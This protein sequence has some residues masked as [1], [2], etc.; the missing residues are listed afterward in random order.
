VLASD[1]TRIVAVGVSTYQEPNLTLE[2]GAANARALAEA[3]VLESGCAI[4]PGNVTLLCDRSASRD[5]ILQALS[6]AASSCSLDGTLIFYFSGHGEQSNGQFYLL[7]TEASSDNLADTAISSNDLN[8]VLTPC[9]ARGILIILDCCKSAGFAENAQS[10]FTT[11]AGYDFRLLLSASR[12]GQ[13]SFEFREAQGTLF[14]RAVV[15]VVR[16]DAGSIGPMA[17]VVYFSDLFDYV[18]KQ[19]AE[20]LES[21]GNSPEMQEPVFAGTYNRDPRL[22]ILKRLSLERLEAE[23]PRY[24]GKFVRRRIRRLATMGAGFLI[25]FLAGY[26][27]YLDHSLYVWHESSIVKGREGDFLSIYSGDPRFNWSWLGFPHRIFTTDIGV[28]ALDSAVRPG[29]GTPLLTHWSNYIKGLLFS[30]LSPE[31]QTTVSVWN[32][33]AVNAWKYAKSID[34]FDNPGSSGSG[35]AAVA[36]GWISGPK[37]IDTLQNLAS[38]TDADVSTLPVLR[39]VAALAP[40]Q[41]LDILECGFDK[42]LFKQAVMEGLAQPC[43]PTVA[44]FLEREVPTPLTEGEIHNAWYGAGIRTGCGLS[45]DILL[46]T[47][48]SGRTLNSGQLDWLPLLATSPPPGFGRRLGLVLKSKIEE[49]AHTNFPS[50]RYNDLVVR[51]WIELRTLAALWPNEVPQFATSL[52]T[53]PYVYVRYSA[54]YALA[55]KSPEDVGPIAL[56]HSADPWVLTGLV[57]GGWFDE[58]IIG[59]SIEAKATQNKSGLNA[60]AGAAA[61]LLLRTLRLRHLV[62]AEGLAR[63]MAASNVPMIKLEALR[64]LDSLARPAGASER[65]RALDGSLDPSILVR[66]DANDRSLLLD[67]TYEWWVR[68]DSGA[69]S[70][71]LKDLGDS[72]DEAA[73]VLGKVMIPP[74]ILELLRKALRDPTTALKAATLLAMRGS[75]NDLSKLLDSPD[76]NLRNQGLLYAVYNPDVE[77]YL[78]MCGSGDRL[79][80]VCGYLRQQEA[81]RDELERI[82]NK[83]PK[84]VRGLAFSVLGGVLEFT[85]W[86]ADDVPDVS[87][88]IRLWLTD[89]IDELEGTTVDQLER[90]IYTPPPIAK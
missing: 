4:P 49:L 18:Q 46:K 57:R 58:A 25:L 86:A 55:S 28:G 65:I 27:Y 11:L 52:L 89:R 71:Y 1:V 53:S 60:E 34:V 51:L 24:S 48:D 40:E 61:T 90:D 70:N 72:P 29:V 50:D 47:L 59:R 45:A 23:A 14:T 26:Y 32:A 63:E 33:D 66:L 77:K 3:L 79:T 88:G 43:S 2:F 6:S 76:V 13:P 5:A 15:R 81:K 12:V 83:V 7:P 31:W 36:L 56:R 38:P 64:T 75:A 30:R 82:G 16:G 69:L 85:I 67:G 62:A 80:M 54:A 10:F 22:F 68:N 37:D 44:S 20:D 21:I 78:A 73:H 8:Y 19:V 87:P 42:P 74:K 17:G 84:L 9:R 39:R 35:E 41:A